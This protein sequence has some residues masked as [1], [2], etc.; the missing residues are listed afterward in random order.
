MARKMRFIRH[1][2]VVSGPTASGKTRLLTRLRTG[3]LPDELRALLPEAAHCWPQ[4]SARGLVRG[5]SATFNAARARDLDGL[6]LHYDILRPFRTGIDLARDPALTLLTRAQQVTVLVLY[7]PREQLL[8]RYADRQRARAMRSGRHW[9]SLV[10]DRLI[11]GRRSKRD[12]L[13]SGYRSE[14]WV[15]ARYAEWLTFLSDRHPSAT[16]RAVPS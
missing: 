8:R 4:M 13:L 9:R 16:V 7:P 1:L 2:L 10:L 12:Q 15:R 11:P 3:S 6:V 5:R 14:D